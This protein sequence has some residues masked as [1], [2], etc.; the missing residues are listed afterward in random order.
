MDQYQT[1]IEVNNK[2][3]YQVKITVEILSKLLL[4]ESLFKK[5]INNKMISKESQVKNAMMIKNF[6]FAFQSF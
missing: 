1:F 6:K 2:V 5:V 4:L 3:Q